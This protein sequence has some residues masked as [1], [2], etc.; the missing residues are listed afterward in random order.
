MTRIALLFAGLL[1]AGCAV[2]PITGPLTYQSGS[3]SFSLPA[4][5][6]ITMYGEGGCGHAF[7]EAPGEAIVY[8]KG[9]PLKNDTGIEKYARTLS[10]TANFWPPFIKI[11]DRTFSSF[12]DKRYGPAVKETFNATFGKT[13][14]PHTRTYYRRAGSHCA[15]YL[16][17]QS[18]DEDAGEVA[19][20]FSQILNSFSAK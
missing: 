16:L 3:M 1:L 12:Q 11:T 19:A 4:N 6:K 18:S 7:V 17:T 9:T 2:T 10:R 8:I 5:W 15:F 20:G 14:V 13:P